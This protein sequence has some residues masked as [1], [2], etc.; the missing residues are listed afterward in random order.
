[1]RL[2]A[3]VPALALRV[4]LV[5]GILAFP[6]PFWA[7][8]TR[9]GGLEAHANGAEHVLEVSG[10]IFLATIVVLAGWAVLLVLGLAW[11][12]RAWPGASREGALTA[13]GVGMA[14]VLVG[15][16]AWFAAVLGWACSHGRGINAVGDAVYWVVYLPLAVAGG[17]TWRRALLAWPGAV[18]L[19]GVAS[20]GVRIAVL[21][22]THSCL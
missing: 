22:G 18:I 17:S 20:L 12:P 8:A 3:D 14:S 6:Y 21:G 7:I 13:V 19:A 9:G 16:W 15:G 11:G 5:G 1:L 10:A 2:V 4:L